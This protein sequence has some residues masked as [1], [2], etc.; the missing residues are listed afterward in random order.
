M[1][2]SRT[3]RRQIRVRFVGSL[4]G[5]RCRRRPHPDGAVDYIGRGYGLADAL[6]NIWPVVGAKIVIVVAVLLALG[7]I[8]GAIRY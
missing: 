1:P 8:I 7:A 4:D 5:R 3:R 6:M 2:S